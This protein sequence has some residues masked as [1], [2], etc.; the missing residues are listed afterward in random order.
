MPT[1]AA[2]GAIHGRISLVTVD[3]P[4]PSGVQRGVQTPLFA[5]KYSIMKKF[6]WLTFL[7][8]LALSGIAGFYSIVG[9]GMIFAGAFWSV[10]VLAGMLEI[11]KIVAVSWMY[12]YRH[13]AGTMVKS[14]FVIATMV[15]MFITSM[16]IFGYLTR[17]HV[18]TEAAVAAAELTL[19]EIDQR[20]QSLKDQR[21]QLNK[22]L[23]SIASQSNILVNQLGKAERFVGNSGAVN[24]QR[25]TTKRRDVLLKEIKQLNTDIS[26]VQKERIGVET[27]ANVATADVGP[28]R[29]VAQ[30]IFGQDDIATIRKSVVWLTVILMSVFDPM[31]IMLLIAANILFLTV[32]QEKDA[33][34]ALHTS[35]ISSAKPAP[36]RKR[37][38]IAPP[39]EIALDALG[40]TLV[41]PA[42]E[43]SPTPVPTTPDPP[44]PVLDAPPPHIDTLVSDI[45]MP[46]RKPADPFAKN[47][48]IEAQVPNIVTDR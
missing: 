24:V 20:E 40:D 8:G 43:P 48:Y 1:A 12:R 7:T 19:K 26:A 32:Q 29:Y 14:Y 30:A 31:A 2:C 39:V 21:D 45:P 23:A 17:A 42:P 28:L 25:E 47:A 11:A 22:E 18:G 34:E 15:L 35:A 16:G 41:V 10:V 6:A 5:Y 46:L 37:E 38:H 36:K 33:L 9:L 27:E 3:N 44:P 4:H 13:L